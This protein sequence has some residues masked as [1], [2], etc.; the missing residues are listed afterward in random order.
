MSSKIAAV[1]IF[2]NRR[3]FWRGSLCLKNN[4]PDNKNANKLEF[5]IPVKALD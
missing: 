5:K 1:Q 3:S 4:E 2:E